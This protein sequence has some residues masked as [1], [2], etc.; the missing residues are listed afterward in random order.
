MLLVGHVPLMF[1]HCWCER[2]IIENQLKFFWWI[3]VKFFQLKRERER[4]TSKRSVEVEDVELLVKPPVCKKKIIKKNYCVIMM[5]V[6]CW[7]AFADLFA[8]LSCWSSFSNAWW[9]SKFSCSIL[10]KSTCFPC[11]AA[12]AVADAWSARF[13]R[14][15][16][17]MYE[18]CLA[19]NS[20]FA[21]A[22]FAWSAEP[23]AMFL[24]PKRIKI[25]IFCSLRNQCSK[26]SSRKYLNL[27]LK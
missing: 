12:M 14:L 4:L 5:M 21:T 24:R 26:F 25:T 20:W 13:A 2:E 15:F 3:K 22:E 17:A 19:A 6:T 7:A 23:C 27:P 10:A 18:A 11:N 9:A 1:V 16:W 8:C